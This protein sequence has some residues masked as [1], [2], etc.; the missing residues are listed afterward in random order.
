[1]PDRFVTMIAVPALAIAIL[2]GVRTEVAGQAPKAAPKPAARAIPRMSDGHP[3]L[4]GTYDLA[5]LTPVERPAGQPLVLTAEQAQKLEQ[6]V[7]ERSVRADAPIAAN[8]AAP[9]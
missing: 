8:R 9:P 7:A 2:C 6:Q 5:T 3:D 1:M 4:Q